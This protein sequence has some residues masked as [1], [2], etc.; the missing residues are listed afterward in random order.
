MPKKRSAAT[1]AGD[2]LVLFDAGFN[3]ARL[4]VQIRAARALLNWSQ[5]EL[6]RRADLTQ[7]SIHRLEQGSSAVRA[8]TA[9]A[10][11]EAFADAGVHF[12]ESKD[13]GITITVP[14]GVI[15]NL[16]KF[17]HIK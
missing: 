6:A 5:A 2:Y 9:D 3:S 1:R 13:G 15:T 14:A 8:S 11:A 12:E 4:A 16:K 7:R 17:S 10:L